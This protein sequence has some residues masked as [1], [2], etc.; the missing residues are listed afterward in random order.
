MDDEGAEV[1]IDLPTGPDGDVVLRAI[2]DTGA[3][4]A[5]PYLD[6]ALSEGVEEATRAEG[7]GN[8]MVYRRMR[9]R[10]IVIGATDERENWPLPSLVP[11]PGMD[12]E[13]A[14]PERRRRLWL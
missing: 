13:R 14:A 12:R 2:E 11:T 9:V 10:S 6:A 8:V 5:R 4:L 7:A 1:E 3:V